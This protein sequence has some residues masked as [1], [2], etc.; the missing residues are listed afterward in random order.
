MSNYVQDPDNSKKVVPGPKPDNAYDRMSGAPTAS[1]LK[2]PNSVYVAAGVA[3]TVGFFFGGSASFSEKASAESGSA[4]YPL[5]LTG[6]EHY[7][8][9]PGTTNDQYLNI[10]PSAWS[11]SAADNDGGY[12][13]F[14]YNSAL[15]TGGR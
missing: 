3:N 7:D 11:G 4:P 10:H 8:V 12:V 15:S 5:V 13:K 2:T 9:F 6:S 1:L 14:I